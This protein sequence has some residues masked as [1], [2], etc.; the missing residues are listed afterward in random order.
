M[1]RES[2]VFPAAADAAMSKGRLQSVQSQ[3]SDAAWV[4]QIEGEQDRGRQ[5]TF[6]DIKTQQKLL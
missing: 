1:L 6:P 4:E 3:R 5:K 2:W